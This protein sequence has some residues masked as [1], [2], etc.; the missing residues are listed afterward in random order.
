MDY[1][2]HVEAVER[3]TQLMVGALRLHPRGAGADLPGL[4]ARRLAAHVGEFTA[5]W[6]HV[7]CEA[8]G[9][10]TT[11][12]APLQDTDD[13]GTWYEPLAGHL[14]DRLHATTGEVP[15]WMWMPDQQ[16][17]FGVARRCSNE[18]SIHRYDART[19]SGTTTPLEAAV[20]LDTIDEIFVMLPAWDNPPEGSGKK[21]SLRA[22]G[23]CGA[24]DHAGT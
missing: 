3:E 22:R 13:M 8:T 15:A 10:E 14:L 11:S 17:V 24:H 5:L 20:A 21:L 2:A 9:V 18:L 4:L 23:R 16:T 12:Y 7:L 6:T 1:G 19:S